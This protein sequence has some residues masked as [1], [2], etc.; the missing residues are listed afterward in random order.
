MEPFLMPRKKNP[1]PNV[2]IAP[3]MDM[4]FILLIF[5]VVTSTFTQETGVDV[6]KPQ[7]QSARSLKSEN[8][9][10]AITREGTLHLNERQIDAAGLKDVLERMLRANPERDVVLMA[11]RRSETGILVKVMDI[12]NLAGAKK[13]S[14]AALSE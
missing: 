7:A 2:D 3:L 6:E 5:F 10:I 4:V 14:V 8:I 12:C 11:D 13:V 9:L 1:S